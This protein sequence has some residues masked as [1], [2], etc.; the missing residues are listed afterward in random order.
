MVDAAAGPAAQVWLVRYDPRIVQVPVA[1]GENGG[2]TL[3][4]RNVVKELVKLGDWSGKPVS[5]PLPASHDAAL[6][7]AV[8]V[9]AGSGGAIL[10]ANRN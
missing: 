1:R 8:L 9:Q 4:H 5:Y 10:A 6:R 3:P 2:Q 7:D